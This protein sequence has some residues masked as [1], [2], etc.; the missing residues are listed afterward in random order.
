MLLT[1]SDAATR[2]GVSRKTVEREIADGRLAIVRV[3]RA[4]KIAPAELDRYIAAQTCHS[5]STAIDGRC[6][7]AWAAADALSAAFRLAQ[8]APTRRRSKLVSATSFS[9]LQRV[10]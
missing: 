4:R 9:H 5:A 6:A 10:K 8:P 1:L 2:L 3:R 7:S